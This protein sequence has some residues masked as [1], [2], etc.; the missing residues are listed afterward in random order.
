VI[1][2]GEMPASVLQ[3]RLAA[4]S[5]S[6]ANIVCAAKPPFSDYLK[7]AAADLSPNGL[8][9]LADP[10]MQT[11]Y[12]EII[13]AAELVVLDNISTLCRSLKENDA[14]SW[15]SIQ[16]F[17]LALRRAGKSVVLIHHD[18]KSGTQRGTSRKEDVLDTV[19]SLRRPPDY[20]PSQGARFEIHFEKSRGF[21]GPEAEPFE[22]HLVDGQWLV[23][24]IKSGSDVETLVA[25][26]KL[27]MSIRDISDRTGV[28]KSTVHRLMRDIA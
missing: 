8:P 26:H 15:A 10:N 18:G 27:G 14:D 28:P 25:L 1:L 23:N 16:S 11:Q 9:D 6:T 13:G 17:V 24:P 2:D 21:F 20:D 22:A 12:L 7:I 4:V 3:E 19:I 5:A